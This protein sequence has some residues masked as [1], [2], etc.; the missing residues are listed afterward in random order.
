MKILIYL[1]Q[2][3]LLNDTYSSNT[4][5]IH[6]HMKDTLHMSYGL[7]L[8]PFDFL[9]LRCGYEARETSI[10]KD[11][12]SLLIPFPDLDI[13]GA[14]IGIILKNGIQVDVS[15]SYIT[16]DGVFFL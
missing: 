13:F 14:G 11:Y 3:K 10:N 16:N 9:S 6:Q 12:Y 7:E 2:S 15:A 4:L 5:V 8:M 1:F